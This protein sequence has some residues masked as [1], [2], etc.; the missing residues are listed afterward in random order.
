MNLQ[1]Y[2]INKSTFDLLVSK[3]TISINELYQLARYPSKSLSDFCGNLPN[4]DFKNV[5]KIEDLNI[6]YFLNTLKILFG[7]G[8]KEEQTVFQNSLK[9]EPL[10]TAVLLSKL[11]NNPTER[12]IVFIENACKI[13]LSK[14][15]VGLFLDPINIKI[16]GSMPRNFFKSRQ[17]I[18]N[19]WFQTF[20]EDKL[21]IFKRVCRC[22]KI[23]EAFPILVMSIAYSLY[24]F[25]P[26]RYHISYCEDEDTALHK[27][28]KIFF[29]KI[30]QYK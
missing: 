28:I 15:N 9:F 24:T 8:N 30:N 6:Y 22:Y 19:L 25:T 21:I 23:E 11:Q 2:I 29:E 18:G 1:D 10:R 14:P 20:I 13:M 3:K 26:Q 7:L 5:K 17:E 12:Y 27:V 16:E 4:Y